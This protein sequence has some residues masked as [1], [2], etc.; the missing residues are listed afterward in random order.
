MYDTKKLKDLPYP[1]AL[2]ADG[3]AESL[4]DESGDI[5]LFPLA[6]HD[7]TATSELHEAGLTDAEVIVDLEGECVIRY[8]VE[9]D[10][11]PVASVLN[12]LEGSQRKDNVDV[13]PV[14]VMVSDMLDA[15]LERLGKLPEHLSIADLAVNRTAGRAELIA[16]YTLPSGT[17]EACYDLFMS[18]CKDMLDRSS[19]KEFQRHLTL[20]I[21]KILLERRGRHG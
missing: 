18:F 9:S 5:Y 12:S 19:T 3:L 11:I 4:V 15:T 17:P 21:D 14:L 1:A 6:E 13:K 10:I 2:R 8:P 7:F 16:P 20:S